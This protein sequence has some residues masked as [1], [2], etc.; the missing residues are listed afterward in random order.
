MK[1]RDV[2]CWLFLEMHLQLLKPKDTKNII[3]TKYIKKLYGAI[4][5]KVNNPYP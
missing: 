5:Y 1:Q 3:I 4:T 2:N